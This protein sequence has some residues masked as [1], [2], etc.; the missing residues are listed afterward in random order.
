MIITNAACI[1][2]NAMVSHKHT[3]NSETQGSKNIDL[4]SQF[5]SILKMLRYNDE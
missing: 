3:H 5:V 2:K 4:N 1:G